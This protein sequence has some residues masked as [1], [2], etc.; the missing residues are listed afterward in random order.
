MSGCDSGARCPGPETVRECGSRARPVMWP[1][2][3]ASPS[4]SWPDTRSRWP[5]GSLRRARGPAGDAAAVPGGSTA[6]SS[7]P[8]TRRKGVPASSRPV[9]CTY[10]PRPPTRS[11][12]S[13]SRAAVWAVQMN[14]VDFH[15][16]PVP[17][18]ET[19]TTRTSCGSTSTRSRPDFADAAGGPALHDVLGELG[20]TAWSK[21]SGNRGVHVYARSGRPTSSWTSGTPSSAS[22]ASSSAVCRT[23]SRRPGGRRSA[24][25][26]SSSTSTRR[27]ET[28]P[29]RGAYSP[30]PLPGAPVSTPVGW[31]AR[32]G[33]PGDF[34]VR[35]VPE[36]LARRPATPW[37][38]MED[39][40]RDRTRARAGG[41]ADVQERG[42]GEMPFPPDYPRC[43]ASRPA[44][45]PPA[46]GVPRPEPGPRAPRAR[47]RPV[48]GAGPPAARRGRPRPPARRPW[49]PHRGPVPAR[50]L[51]R[52]SGRP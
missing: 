44:F 45:S 10:P 18:P 22:P 7:S 27:T 31:D 40:W 52:R 28:A 48:R 29:S 17:R 3:W 24:A 21:T 1:E 8:R 5:T 51:R 38:G 26:G 36:R 30:R 20:L 43:P 35:T 4:G 42:L 32:R 6:R 50:C 46:P 16:W 11:W 12:S 23:R 34:T 37:A 14:T 47:P 33:H 25:S 13:T 9:T 19:P 39:A 41:S 2:D 15:P 49:L